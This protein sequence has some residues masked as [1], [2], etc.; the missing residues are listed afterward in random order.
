MIRHSVLLLCI[1]FSEALPVEDAVLC[2]DVVV[3]C[4]TSADLKPFPRCVETMMRN[5]KRPP[6]RVRLQTPGLYFKTVDP[7]SEVRMDTEYGHKIRIPSEAVQKSSGEHL[8]T[9]DH[10]VHLTVSVLDP[11]LFEAPPD[12]A[13][14]DKQILGVWLGVQDVHNLFHPVRIVFMNVSQNGSAKCVFWKQSNNSEQGPE[15]HFQLFYLNLYFLWQELCSETIY[16]SCNWSA[17]GCST[18]QNNT[19]V[20]CKCNHLSFFAV[21]VS[22]DVPSAVD[23]QRLTY[24]SYIGSSLSV[25]FTLLVLILFVYH[26]RP[27]TEHSI[28]VHMQLT[29]SLFLL[30]LF[31]LASAF[32]SKT[33]NP[34]CQSLGLMLHWALLATFTWTAIEGFH[35]YLLLVRVFNIY[36]RRYLQKL[37]LVG[38]GLPTVTVIICGVVGVYGKH[39]IMEKPS[40]G[41]DTDLCWFTSK[42]ISSA[43]ITMRYVTVNGYLGLV[44]LFNVIILTVTVVKMRQMRAR[45]FQSRDRMRNM[46]KDLATV[47][48]LSCI[49]GLPWG[50][51]FT[52]Q[53]TM[54]LPGTYLFSILNGFQG[55]FMFLWFLSTTC[56]SNHE[57]QKST[58]DFSL[59]HPS[60]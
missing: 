22:P 52:T 39:S 41:T 32:W 43:Y 29:G 47:L 12:E 10:K 1:L 27:K 28:A 9:T 60:L 37:S 59:S 21:L 53:G 7:S 36:I 50:L 46:W 35:L 16:I 20:I 54:S 30:H 5:C 2:R 26:R 55:V 17:D 15:P 19:D 51:A 58:K 24:I 31:F 23:V 34:V 3:I 44:L 11:K 56:K 6:P 45:S 57:E 49:L 48:G 33:E 18:I 14:P 13:S 8:N 4:K 25:V 42:N 40:T 38:W